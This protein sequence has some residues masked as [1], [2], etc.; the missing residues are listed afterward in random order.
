MRSGQRR[1]E[2]ARSGEDRWTRRA[3]IGG[4][5]GLGRGDSERLEIGEDRWTCRAGIGGLVGPGRGDSERLERNLRD[6]G[7]EGGI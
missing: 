4:L 7:R 5:V 3:G 2:T 6:D 1:S